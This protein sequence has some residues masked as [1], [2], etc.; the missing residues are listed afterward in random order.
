MGPMPMVLGPREP[1][2]SV[3]PGL[4]PAH[5]GAVAGGGSG[6]PFGTDMED[7]ASISKSIATWSDR[8]NSPFRLLDGDRL[9]RVGTLPWTMMEIVP[10]ET[11]HSL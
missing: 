4:A 9:S 11:H 10:Q 1:G 8:L 6:I 2:A 5:H 7:S 3:L